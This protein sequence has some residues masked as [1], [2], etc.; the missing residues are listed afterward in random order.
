MLECNIGQCLLRSSGIGKP[1]LLKHFDVSC[2][3]VPPTDQFWVMNKM[4]DQPW[5]SIVDRLINNCR[6]HEL[7]MSP[8]LMN[9]CWMAS[10][11]I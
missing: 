11:Y 1:Q 8:S 2:P 3:P 5:P 6:K 4:Q 9:G 10:A 7:A